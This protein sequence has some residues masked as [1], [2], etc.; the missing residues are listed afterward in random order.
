MTSTHH[1]DSAA[2]AAVRLRAR[3][4][5]L[6]A[7][8]AEAFDMLYRHCGGDSPA[9]TQ[10]NRS[11]DR[12]SHLA[13]LLADLAWVHGEHQAYEGSLPSPAPEA[14]AVKYVYQD[15]SRLGHRRHL[16]NSEQ[17]A[18]V[19]AYLDALLVAIASCID[20]DEHAPSQTL[21]RKA[22]GFVTDFTEV[23]EAVAA[24]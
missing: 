12:L 23:R 11:T 22:R 19:L 7:G 3:L 9:G 14:M 21:A 13:A 4:R 5:S 6:T 18:A 8:Q 2:L 20:L 24:L 1:L 15:F 16:M 10:I 17:R